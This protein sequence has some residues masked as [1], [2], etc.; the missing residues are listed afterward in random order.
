MRSWVGKGEG[1]DERVPVVDDECKNVSHVLWE[2]PAYSSVR[3]N[4]L[5]ALQG[6]LE[7]D[8][9]KYFLSLDSFRKASFIMGGRINFVLWLTLLKVLF[10]MF[11]S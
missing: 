2:C 10:W 11:G 5:V 8:G 9:F 1:G 3:S 7:D 4:F 6:K